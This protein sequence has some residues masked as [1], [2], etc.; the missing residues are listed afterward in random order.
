MAKK[1]RGR[2]PALANYPI[3]EL[4]REMERRASQVG[5]MVRERDALLARVSE[6]EA[7]ISAFDGVLA[8]RAGTVRRP[9]RPRKAAPTRGST[10]R[11]RPKNDMS[12]AEALVKL[13][14]NRTMGVTE[15]TSAVQ[16]A[17]YKTN[18][19]NFRTIVNQTLIKD[20][21]FKKISRGQ[22]TAA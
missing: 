22:Y 17:G 12:L 11:K 10:G 9:G 1:R 3:A 2:R 8:V 19:E 6:L 7:E 21:R 5:D 16:K 20:A 13:L 18:A 4:Q 14:K 15:I